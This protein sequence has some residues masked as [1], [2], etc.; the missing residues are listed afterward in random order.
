MNKVPQKSLTTVDRR[1]VV[2]GLFLA[3]FSSQ[4]KAAGTLGKILQ[5]TSPLDIVVSGEDPTKLKEKWLNLGYAKDL[6][7]KFLSA[8]K[9]QKVTCIE[10]AHRIL[11]PLVDLFPDGE[12][13]QVRIYRRDPSL[14]KENQVFGSG[15]YGTKNGSDVLENCVTRVSAECQIPG[16]GES[17]NCS[18]PKQSARGTISLKIDPDGSIEAS[19]V[20]DT[21]GDSW[22]ASGTMDSQ[23]IRVGGNQVPELLKIVKRWQLQDWTPIINQNRV[24][25]HERLKKAIENHNNSITEK[26]VRELRRRTI[27]ILKGSTYLTSPEEALEKHRNLKPSTA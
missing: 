17:L 15:I 16:L 8:R 10:H 3:P 26:Q 22:K 13:P 2:R 23:I 19:I 6:V 5:A 7:D 12:T 9:S 21:T 14:L 20:G 27:S 4:I 11:E 1:T 24:A 25:A 18:D